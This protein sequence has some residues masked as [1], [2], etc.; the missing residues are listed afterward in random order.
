MSK[1]CRSS[2]FAAFL[3]FLACSPTFPA[4]DASSSPDRVPVV[5]E[6]RNAPDFSVA[7]LDEPGVRG[8]LEE[9]KQAVA[10]GKR[11]MLAGMIAY[12][13][14]VSK[15]GKRMV[16]RNKADFINRYGR[17]ITSGV[18][19]AVSGAEPAN[20]SVN[21]QGVRIGRG[22]VWFA[23]VAEGKGPGKGGYRIKVVAIN[24]P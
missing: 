23:A 12:P 18:A 1:T 24:V 8:F 13:L 14:N 10:G 2:I 9:L 21:Y 3:V 6:E 22:E 19:G 15:G 20:L 7:G 11:A 17:I 5:S 16:I 4:Q